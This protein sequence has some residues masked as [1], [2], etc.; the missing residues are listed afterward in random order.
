MPR[1]II[2]LYE[3]LLS[4]A[5]HGINWFSLKIQFKTLEIASND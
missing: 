1:I 3:K 4:W 5:F 2:P